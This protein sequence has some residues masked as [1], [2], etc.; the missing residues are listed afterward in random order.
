MLSP[1][2]Q[3]DGFGE[4]G[5]A[6]VPGQRGMLALQGFVHLPG[7]AA[8]AEVAGGAGTQFGDVLGLGKVHLEEAAYS[9]GQRQKV[10]GG[11][12]GLRGLARSDAGAG[13]VGGV[14]R[15]LELGANAGLRKRVDIRAEVAGVGD[16][17]PVQHSEFLLDLRGAAMAVHVA[18]TTDVHEDVE[19]HGRS[20]V[21]CAQRFI[22]TAAVT[23]TELD[24]TAHKN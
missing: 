22:V 5:D 11:L 17:A 1:L 19:A 20:G 9:C 24:N 6:D 12:G 10:E 3:V 7:Y 2:Q 8:V 4:I 18:K 13:A 15:S 21:K 16:L 14:E 23:Q